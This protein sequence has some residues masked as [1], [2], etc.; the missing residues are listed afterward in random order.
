MTVVADLAAKWMERREA[1]HRDDAHVAG[2]RLVAEFIADLHALCAAD[3]DQLLNLRQA[4]VVSGYSE[5]YLGRLIRNGKM[6]NEGRTNRPLV[7]R[8]ALPKKATT[9][10][11]GGVAHQ[12]PSAARR[13]SLSAPETGSTTS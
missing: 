6:A 11:S 5:G 8:S 3:D 1:Y 10:H 2:E 12:F 7:R 4:A 9:L 13:L